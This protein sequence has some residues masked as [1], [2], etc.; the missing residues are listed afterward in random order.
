MFTLVAPEPSLPQSCLL[1]RSGWHLAD[2]CACVWWHDSGAPSRGP[3]G[4]AQPDTHFVSQKIRKLAGGILLSCLDLHDPSVSSCPCATSSKMSQLA[5][6][7]ERLQ[8]QSPGLCKPLHWSSNY[9][10]EASIPEDHC[11]VCVLCTSRWSMFQ[12]SICGCGEA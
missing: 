8:M 2:R 11:N 12:I 3:L 4:I 7:Q 1:C 5:V 9:S 6:H 10:S